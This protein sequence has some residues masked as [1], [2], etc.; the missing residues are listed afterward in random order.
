MGNTNVTYYGRSENDKI[1]KGTFKKDKKV[2]TAQDI[3]DSIESDNRSNNMKKVKAKNVVRDVVGAG[4]T[5]GVGATMLGAMGQGAIAGKVIT[6][7]A[8]MMGPVAT[9]GMGMSVIGM[10]GDMMPKEKKKKK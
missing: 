5:L 3:L 2:Q 6:P 1:W 4:V 8:N 10:M 7:A 9:A